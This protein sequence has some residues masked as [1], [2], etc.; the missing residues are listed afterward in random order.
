MQGCFHGASPDF[1]SKVL[2]GARCVP[3]LTQLQHMLA[4]LWEGGAL[5][6]DKSSVPHFATSQ[7]AGASEFPGPDVFSHSHGKLEQ[8]RTLHR[9][10][11]SA[12]TGVA[13]P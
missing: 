5:V 9:T 2:M 6:E 12:C 11:P 1:G 10:W 4:M 8:H 7:P 3:T 13:H